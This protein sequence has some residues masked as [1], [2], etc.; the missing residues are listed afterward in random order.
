MQRSGVSK[1]ESKSSPRNKKHRDRNEEWLISR[2]KVD[3][4]DAQTYIKNT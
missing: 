3:W 1:K 2:L 4:P